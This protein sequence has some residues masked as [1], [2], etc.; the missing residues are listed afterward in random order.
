MDNET[1]AIRNQNAVRAVLRNEITWILFIFGL[2]WGAIATVILP[3]QKLQIQVTQVQ[4]QLIS[5]QDRYNLINNELKTVS[6]K[7][8]QID[9]TLQNHLN[10]K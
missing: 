2:I 9:T 7:Q 5:E 4:E 8:I 6:D 3:L 10:G 1:P